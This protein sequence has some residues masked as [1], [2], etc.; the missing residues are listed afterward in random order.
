M[1]GAPAG[2]RV[3]V[4]E[5]CWCWFQHIQRGGGNQMSQPWVLADDLEGAAPAGEV[6][7]RVDPAC[8]LAALVGQGFLGESGGVVSVVLLE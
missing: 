8:G 2:L 3:I 5:V 7:E 4:A 1:T 6:D